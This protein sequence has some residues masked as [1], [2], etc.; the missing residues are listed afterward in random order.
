MPLDRPR[1]APSTPRLPSA[2]RRAASQR[3]SAG[4]RLPAARRYCALLEEAG[5]SG[6][7]EWILWVMD[8]TLRL[9]R[10]TMTRDD[11]QKH[12]R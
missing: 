7:P 10:L 9:F 2:L 11:F 5:S 3:L 12:K 4:C 8:E 1:A 6:G